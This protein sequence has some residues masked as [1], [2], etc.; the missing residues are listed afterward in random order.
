[1][2]L[3]RARRLVKMQ[4]LTAEVASDIIVALM[5]AFCQHRLQEDVVKDGHV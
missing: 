4:Q 2:E 1:M 5:L 3:D